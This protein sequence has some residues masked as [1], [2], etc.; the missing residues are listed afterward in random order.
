MK[1]KKVIFALKLNL[2][3]LILFLAI[4]CVII[5][6]TASLFVNYYIQKKQLIDISLSVNKEY[7]SKIAHNTNSQFQMILKELS[8][9]ANL[10][11]DSFDK[12]Q[13][14]QSEVDRL[15]FQSNFFNSVIVSDKNGKI[16]NYAPSQIALNKDVIN[17]TL[18]FQQSIK[19]KNTVITSPY[20]S[21]RNNLIVFISQPI[22][23]KDKNYLGF[24][25]GAIYLKDPNIVNELLTSKYGYKDSYMY[26]LDNSRKIIFHPNKDRIGTLAENNTGL[27][28]MTSNDSGQIRLT[29]SQGVD[30]LAGFA[31]VECT[32]WI[33]VSQQPTNKLLE[34]IPNLIYK[35]IAYMFVFYLL[36]FFII[37]RIS[38]LISTPLN[39]LATIASNLNKPDIDKQIKNVDPWYFE[40]RNFKRSLLQSSYNFKRKIS[41][42]NHYIN[43]D[44][45]TGLYNRRGMELHIDQLM[46]SKVPFAIIAIDIDHFKKINDQYG[47]EQ[48]DLV[49]KIT[50][51]R[52]K[53]NFRDIDF[54]CRVG[55]EEFIII[56]PIHNQKL[57]LNIAERVREIL[58]KSPI[59]DI[60][61]VTISMGIAHW[62]QTSTDI[63]KVFRIADEYLYKAKTEGRNC[64]RYKV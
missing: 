34:K 44:P 26:V 55:G 38:D 62:P 24:I 54:C 50:A 29:N 7:A 37:W 14:V 56:S 52:I 16:L 23:D 45:L 63:N 32:N 1:L 60:P 39:R 20:Y 12:T 61:A 25:G 47:H 40:V 43:T 64:I 19:T 5:L 46:K 35:I 3:K 57:S 41:T 9:S 22:F 42:L 36:V 13:F 30:N 11:G 33:V 58:E 8:Y 31:K 28:F 27:D 59:D 18:G 51:Q 2:R 21:I 10:L 17:T 4:F 6:F 53:D 49:L 15:K 48:G